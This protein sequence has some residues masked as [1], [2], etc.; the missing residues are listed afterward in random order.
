MLRW[1][2]SWSMPPSMPS[3][4]KIGPN[5]VIDWLARVTIWRATGARSTL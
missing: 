5:S 4:S 3:A 1:I 2:F